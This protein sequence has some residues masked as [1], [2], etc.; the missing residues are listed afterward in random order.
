M[1]K[2]RRS[3]RDR[4][5]REFR[6]GHPGRCLQCHEYVA[7]ALDRHMMNNH[8]ELG[9]LWRCPVEWRAVWKG[10]LA[11]CLAHLQEKHGKSQFM[12]LNNLEK[13]FPP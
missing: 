13:N 10:S 12:T 1:E 8:L 4:P 9:K 2:L 7:P 11:D 5:E 6:Q 3:C